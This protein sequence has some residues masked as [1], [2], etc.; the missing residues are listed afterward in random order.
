MNHHLM[1]PS[2]APLA[3]PPTQG[4]TPSS[5]RSNF[6]TPELLSR[7]P[8]G[9]DQTQKVALSSSVPMSPLMSQ[10]GSLPQVSW[11]RGVSACG[12]RMLMPIHIPWWMSQC[13]L[14]RIT[15]NMVLADS[16]QY[17]QLQSHM[18]MWCDP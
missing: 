16:N 3:G 13:V 9:L 17:P 8:Q 2:P 1:P 4:V 18:V 10:L 15:A 14:H 7:L 6:I 11:L 5:L 12:T